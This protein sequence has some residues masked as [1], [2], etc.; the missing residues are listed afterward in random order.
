MPSVPPPLVVFLLL[1]TCA[2]LWYA[3]R[4]VRRHQGPP[5]WAGALDRYR[6]L[7]MVLLGAAVLSL[8][9]LGIFAIVAVLSEGI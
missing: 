7:V 6:T 4:G 2:G 8:V 1:T 5:K 9:G 3:A